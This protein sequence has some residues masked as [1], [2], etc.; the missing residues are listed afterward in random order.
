MRSSYGGNG[1]IIRAHQQVDDTMRFGNPKMPQL[2]NQRVA[3]ANFTII[4]EA[5]DNSSACY[6]NLLTYDYSILGL[7]APID[8]S[9]VPEGTSF[10]RDLLANGEIQSGSFSIF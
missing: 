10:R 6:K 2:T 4:R 1:K 3:L 5:A 8:A 7:S 9:D